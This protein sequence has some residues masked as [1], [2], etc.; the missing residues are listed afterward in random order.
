MKKI[1]LVFSFLLLMTSCC[2]AKDVY[3]ATN[4]Y[5]QQYYVIE[6]SIGGVEAKP[7]CTYKLVNSRGELIDRPYQIKFQWRGEDGWFY[8]VD[9]MDSYTELIYP[10]YEAILEYLKDRVHN[11]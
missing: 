3:V 5:N 4:Q 2:L 11:E 6:E 7:Y 10:E 9:Y 1:F 8:K